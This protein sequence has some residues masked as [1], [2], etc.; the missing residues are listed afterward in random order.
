MT[1]SHTKTSI[2]RKYFTDEEGNEDWDFNNQTISTTV[3]IDL[4]RYKCT[5]CNKVMYY[6]QRAEQAYKKG[7]D[8]P[9]INLR[10]EKKD[11]RT[12]NVRKRP[13]KNK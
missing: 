13:K 6:S 5:Q 2:V 11:K 10:I 1:C 3:D 12:K 4:H 7:I 9:L 8:D